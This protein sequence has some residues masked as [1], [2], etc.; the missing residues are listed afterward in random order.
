MRNVGVL[1]IWS[2]AAYLIYKWSNWNNEVVNCYSDEEL[3][4]T[5]LM[6]EDKPY[7]A[8]GKPKDYYASCI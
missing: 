4:Q 3:E 1:L 7:K 6:E 2:L 5:F 8:V